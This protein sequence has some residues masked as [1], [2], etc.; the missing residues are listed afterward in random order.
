MEGPFGAGGTLWRGRDPSG[1]EGFFAET[2][3]ARSCE[4]FGAQDFRLG[5]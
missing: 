1:P 5:C 2:A 4:G 3:L